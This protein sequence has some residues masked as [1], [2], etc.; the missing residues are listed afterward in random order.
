MRDDLLLLLNEPEE[1]DHGIA[2]PTPYA[3]ASALRLCGDL[4]DLGHPCVDS[5]GGIRITW[6]TERGSVVLTCP[7]SGEHS[8]YLSTSRAG[9]S[10]IFWPTQADVTDALRS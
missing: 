8:D 1:D 9:S 5:T 7:E 2:R 4:A 10:L 6:K 3:L